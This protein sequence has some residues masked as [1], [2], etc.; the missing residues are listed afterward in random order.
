MDKSVSIII[1][2]WNEE[3]IILRTCIFLQKLQLPFV[4][5]ELIIIAGGNDNTYNICNEIKLKNFDKIKIIKQ[6]PGDFKSGALI[7]GI[8]EAK[9]NFIILID[10]DTLVAQNLVIEIVK[11][12]KKFDAVNCDYFPLIKKGFWYDFCIIDKLYW[13]RNPNNLSSLYGGATIS[14][15]REII[16]E[17][18]IENFFTN[19]SRAGVD[20]YIGMV[21]K[22]HNKSLGFVKNTRVITPR[23]GNI[24]DFSKD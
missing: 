8:K 20:H 16:K 5:S 17:I 21:L 19:K 10:A 24:K 23:P 7:K 22:K 4:Y 13:A 15:K 6:N 14:L 3:K 1:P 2:A 12:L 18:G 11:S 9:G